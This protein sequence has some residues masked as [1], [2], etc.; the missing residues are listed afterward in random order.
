MLSWKIP[1]ISKASNGA[2]M[3]IPD[4]SKATKGAIMENTVD[5]R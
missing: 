1:D 5:S 2:I 4:I 3:E